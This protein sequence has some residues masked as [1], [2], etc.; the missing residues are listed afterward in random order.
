MEI[1]IVD[2]TEVEAQL[3]RRG[4]DGWWPQEPLTIAA[5]GTISLTSI[6]FEVALM[7]VYRDTHLAST[8]T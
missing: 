5:G 8:S 7:E 4:A 3:L 6:G 1:L 2:S